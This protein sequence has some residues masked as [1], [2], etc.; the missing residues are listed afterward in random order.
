MRGARRAARP[1]ASAATAVSV[2][3]VTAASVAIAL[4]RGNL[5][6]YPADAGPGMDALLRVDPGAL[7]DR[8]P[9]MGLLSVLVRAPFAGIARLAGVG[10]EAE[11]H[12][13]A[14]PCVLAVGLLA[15]WLASIAVRRGTPRVV[16]ALFV[17][18]ALVH[19]I[20]LDALNQGHPEELLGGALVVAAVVAATRGRAA[21]AGLALGAAI[22][23]KQWGTLAAGPAFAAT[24]TA[25]RRRLAAVAIALAAVLTVPLAAGGFT[26]FKAVTTAAASS[27]HAV[28]AYNVWLPLAHNT[29][30]RYR[31]NGRPRVSH[32]HRLDP[33]LGRIARPLIIAL[34]LLL[35]LALALRR[36]GRPE[37]D[38]V[39]AVLALVFLLRCALDPVDNV[40][41]HAP[42]VLAVLA[43]DVVR[44]PR[45]PIGSILA[46]AA[47]YG[48]AEVAAEH[49]SI[50]PLTWLYLAAALCGTVAL[51]RATYGTGRSL[52]Q[53]S[54]PTV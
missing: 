40:Y 14:I 22:A 13:G 38:R 30:R 46:L 17:V 41:Y 49:L 12:W 24:T 54:W 7:L 34:S 26:S 36:G 37:A 43:W 19:P 15:L 8:Q 4:T 11:Y 50:E 29:E 23:T 47:S 2:L 20:V 28:G 39:L 35:P 6:D 3:L 18:V 27:S 21:G 31:E 45:L 32:G 52:S 5:G 16:G 9:L 10:I 25:A 42:F 1:P 33:A 51:T 48:I 44:A 53:T